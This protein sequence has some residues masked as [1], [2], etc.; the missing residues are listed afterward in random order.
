MS[1]TTT[2]KP[3]PTFRGRTILEPVNGI[4]Y[5]SA[6]NWARH[7]G[8]TYDRGRWVRGGV[9]A[10]LEFIQDGPHGGYFALVRA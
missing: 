6:E 10:T 3:A 7:D 9:A 8:W 5:G 2:R 4:S 1:S